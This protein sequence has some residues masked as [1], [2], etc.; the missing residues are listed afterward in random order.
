MQVDLDRYRRVTLTMHRIQLDYQR[1][2]MLNYDRHRAKQEWE[3]NANSI[4]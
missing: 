4:S 2:T 1:L 3:L